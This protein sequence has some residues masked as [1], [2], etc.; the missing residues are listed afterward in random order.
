MS[1]EIKGLTLKGYNLEE[2]SS[3]LRPDWLVQDNAETLKT[4]EH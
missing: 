4:S 3:S 2:G 1:A